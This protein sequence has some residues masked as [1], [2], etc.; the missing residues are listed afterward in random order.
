MKNLFNSIKTNLFKSYSGDAGKMLLHTA[1]LA[2][3]TS[4]IAQIFGIA[5][6][7]KISK[8]QKKFIIP[9]EI[10]DAAIN[11]LAFYTLT[12]TIQNFTKWLASSGKVI[13]PAIK[14]FCVENKI[15]IAKDADGNKPNIGQA[16]LEKVKDF[17]AT[18]RV[19][20]AENIRI[21]KDELDK[22]NK[23]IDKLNSF[24]DKTYAPFESGFK[25]IGNIIGAVVSSNIITPWLRNPIAANKQK[26]SIAME[27]YEAMQKQNKEN[28][29]AV[30]AQNNLSRNTSLMDNYKAKTMIAPSGSMKV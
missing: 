3:T 18:I 22:L 11:I 7:D 4:A 12:N 6:N 29:V 25:I 16:I 15:L 30:P 5:T 1:T 27:H 2:W 28:P 24:Y 21:D 8:D 23:E 14:K 26:Q 19:D 10:A 20:K 9:Q 13:T 17:E